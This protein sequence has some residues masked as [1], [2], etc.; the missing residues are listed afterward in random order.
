MSVQPVVYVQYIVAVLVIAC[1][2]I[3]ESEQ[4]ETSAIT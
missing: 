2:E 4:K 1:W 3:I